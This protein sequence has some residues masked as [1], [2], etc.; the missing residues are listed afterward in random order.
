MI[1]ES[2]K[3]FYHICVAQYTRLFAM[4]NLFQLKASKGC[5]DGSFK[6]LLTLLKGMLPQGNAIPKNI[7]E[8]KQIIY[9]LGLEVK[10]SMHVRMI[11]F[12]IVGLSMKTLRNDLFV[13]ST[14]SIVE[15][16]AVMTRTVTKENAGLK[17]CFG[18]FSSFLVCSIGLQTKRVR[19]VAIVKREA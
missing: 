16:T 11:A 9:L 7:Y 18:T 6:D 1:E 5:S 17:W 10:K 8:V 13:D 2:K 3:S 15:K 14:D 19:I 4:V 12:Y